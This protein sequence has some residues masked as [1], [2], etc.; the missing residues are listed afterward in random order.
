MSVRELLAA[1]LRK[2]LTWFLYQ[3]QTG[4]ILLLP[5]QFHL[6]YPN[7]TTL[8]FAMS[9]LVF[10]I[11]KPARMISV[12]LFQLFLL[13]R[14]GTYSNKLGGMGKSVLVTAHVRSFGLHQFLLWIP[15]QMKG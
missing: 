4:A 9:M 6:Y 3:T 11:W 12:T 10:P 15:Q 2:Y 8:G 5:V 13:W 7:I 1:G 14:L